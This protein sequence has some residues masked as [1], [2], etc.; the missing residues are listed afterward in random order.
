[1]S[2]GIIILL[3]SALLSRHFYRTG[4]RNGFQ[5]GVKRAGELAYPVKP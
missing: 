5:A 2:H 3:V 1:M 4:Y